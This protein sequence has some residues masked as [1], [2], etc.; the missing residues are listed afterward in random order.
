MIYYKD[1]LEGAS[2]DITDFS[3]ESLYERGKFLV[4]YIDNL[5]TVLNSDKLEKLISEKTN[6]EGNSRLVVS[7]TPGSGKTTAMR[8]YIIKNKSVSGVVAMNRMDDIEKFYYDIMSNVEYSSKKPNGYDSRKLEPISRK[9][10]YVLYDSN[11]KKTISEL[12]YSDWIFCTHQRLL[13]DPESLLYVK[14]QGGEIINYQTP[15]EVLFIDEL[16]SHMYTKYMYNEVLPI[17]AANSFL[18]VQL[19]LSP[20]RI[21]DQD[22]L[23]FI[24]SMIS[25][26]NNVILNSIDEAFGKKLNLGR[27]K[28][29]DDQNTVERLT[30]KFYEIFNYCTKYSFTHRLKF[31]SETESYDYPNYIT[32]YSILNFSIKNIIIFDGTADIILR[33]SKWSLIDSPS[34]SLKVDELCK[35]ES[36]VNRSKST[37][38]EII[39]S[40]AD[41]VSKI[42][43]KYQGQKNLLI[44]TWKTKKP[45]SDSEEE[46]EQEIVSGLSEELL[47][48]D[49]SNFN[50]VTY[51]SGKEKSTNEYI[52]SDVVIILGKFFIPNKVIKEFNEANCIS[53]ENPISS[54]DYTRSLMIQLLYRTRARISNEGIDVYIDDGYT[55]RFIDD[56]IDSV[57]DLPPHRG[58]P[59]VSSVHSIYE[60][61]QIMNQLQFLGMEPNLKSKT[62]DVPDLKDL[63]SIKSKSSSKQVIKKATLD[64][65]L[66]SK[67]IKKG[68][69]KGS[70]TVVRITNPLVEES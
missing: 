40:F 24:E 37:L 61:L 18:S 25:S 47:R 69:G 21:T 62:F 41:I 68:G 38:E 20:D 15:R 22:R 19:G 9:D 35:I 26:N 11:N 28:F 59:I 17:L 58:T 14:S 12:K 1:Y 51:K 48:R 29:I 67:I 42:N 65:L 3:P 6:S 5:G 63:L 4:E 31:N 8:Q 46:D 66:K 55:D 43:D 64:G 34:R 16:P 7:N 57:C 52:K 49:I 60:R 53:N 36:N 39:E 30:A 27:I 44:Y 50:I 10:K 13:T 2:P 56:L 45:S 33:D 70:K 32:Y 54:E 23:K